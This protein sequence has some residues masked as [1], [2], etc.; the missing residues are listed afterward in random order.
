MKKG[1]P[2]PVVQPY[3]LRREGVPVI[4]LPVPPDEREGK[5]SVRSEGGFSPSPLA[6]IAAGACCHR[7]AE[8]LKQDLPPACPGAGVAE[9]P[10]F[11]AVRGEAGELPAVIRRPEQYGGRSLPVPARPARLLHVLLHR[12]GALQ[13]HD[14]PHVPLVHAHAVGAGGAEHAA[15]RRE[16][17]VLHGLPLLLLHA[18]MVE[19][20][21]LPPVQGGKLLGHVLRLVPGSAEDYH[22]PG[23]GC[24]QAEGFLPLVQ[25]VRHR[26]TDVRPVRVPTDDVRLPA[27]EHFLYALKDRTGRGGS[28]CGRD[29]GTEPVNHP[30]ELKVCRAEAVAPVAHAVRLVHGDMG[31]PGGGEPGQDLLPPQGLRVRD[32][33]AGSPVRNPPQLLLPRLPALPACED[34]A[35]N[36]RRV[37]LALLVGHQREQGVDHQRGSVQQQ[38]RDQEAEGLARPRREQDNLPGE[39]RTLPVSRRPRRVKDVRDD[40]PLHGVKVADSEGRGSRPAH[41]VVPEDR[42]ILFVFHD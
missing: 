14:R 12:R 15:V 31:N 19:A 18:R 13:V 28:E 38:G 4:E 39:G 33:D 22:R 36:A 20:D 29:P 2:C 11:P 26:V 1:K 9:H 25:A 16:E 30:A 42:G 6:D 24:G 32:D 40:Q 8:G 3:Q 23:A 7:A 35:G 17:P 27:E 34:G 5:R 37:Q 10:A 41:D 21:G